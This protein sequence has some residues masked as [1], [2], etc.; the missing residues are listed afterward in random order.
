MIALLAVL[1]G[2]AGAAARFLLDGWI[3]SVLGARYPVGTLLVN[4]SGSLLF[5]VL[6]GV[7]A[8]A[9]A[10]EEW[11][12]VL[13][14]GFLGG[15]TTFSAAAVEVVQFLRARRFAAAAAHAVGMVALCA[16]LAAVGWG[17]GA[18]IW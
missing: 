2:G 8:Q 9:A 1:A 13:G 12:I 10:A 5:G 3:R 15:Y 17:L 16:A 6:A 7:T 14:A 4:A 18:S 11:R